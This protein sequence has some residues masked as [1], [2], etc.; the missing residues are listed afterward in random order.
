MKQDCL[1]EILVKVIVD[2]GQK[3]AIFAVSKLA[4][5]CLKLSG[6]KRPS[7]REIA[8]ELERLRNMEQ[9]SLQESFQDNHFLSA[10]LTPLMHLPAVK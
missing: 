6:K 2:E 9:T 8:A 10:S 5:S 4:K 7:K 1:F 3:E